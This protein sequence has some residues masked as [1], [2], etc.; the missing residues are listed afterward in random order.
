MTI[1]KGM[2]KRKSKKYKREEYWGMVK[3]IVVMALVVV[4]LIGTATYTV[5]Q[6]TYAASQPKVN[7][8]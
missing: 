8:K 7:T 3:K 1:Y 2:N 4:T 6:T 5:P